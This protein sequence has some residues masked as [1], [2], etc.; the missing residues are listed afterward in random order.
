MTKIGTLELPI[1]RTVKAEGTD[2]DMLDLLMDVHIRGLND[3]LVLINKAKAPVIML[4]KSNEHNLIIL[5]IFLPPDIWLDF[6]GQLYQVYVS[7]NLQWMIHTFVEKRMKTH[8]PFE[9]A[10]LNKMIDYMESFLIK[11]VTTTW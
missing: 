2:Q 1:S 9:L 3:T 6:D 8:D 5:L 11:N 4:V 10:I 7:P